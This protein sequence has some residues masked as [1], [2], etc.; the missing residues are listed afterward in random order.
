MS[1]LLTSISF[2]LEKHHLNKP[3][4][5]TGAGR[6]QAL[7]QEKH[8][9][10]DPAEENPLLEPASFKPKRLLDL[11][12]RHDRSAYVRAAKVEAT[13]VCENSNVDTPYRDEYTGHEAE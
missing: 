11:P 10:L 9:C 6:I 13:N 2:R 3:F 5:T 7:S 8:E 12:S 4:K 1:F